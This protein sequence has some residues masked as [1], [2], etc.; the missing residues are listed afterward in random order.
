MVFMVGSS[1]TLFT[2]KKF[3]YVA[4][5]KSA[6]RGGIFSTVALIFV[7][8]AVVQVTTL[9]GAKGLLVLGALAIA[10]TSPILLYAALAISVPLLGGVLT[11]LGAAVI[12]GIP[13]TLSMLT[14]NVIVVVSGI[15][16]LAVLSQVMPPSALGG[17]FAQELV[18]ESRYGP[19]LKAC[20]VPLVACIAVSIAVLVY[21]DQFAKF[22][23]KY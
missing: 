22:F 6:V 8:G 21:A 10:A 15:S 13:F 17:Y 7:V 18:G 3:N 2:G 9:T 23:V 5:C 1:L 12:L 4:A 14:Q 20:T 19:I 16:M 11:H